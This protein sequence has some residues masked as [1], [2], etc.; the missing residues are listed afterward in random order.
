ML[1]AG[2]V[3]LIVAAIFIA[4][5]GLWYAA[6]D[7]VVP[8]TD[9]AQS[10]PVAL[11]S[12]DEV[13]LQAPEVTPPSPTKEVVARAESRAVSDPLA[14][15]NAAVR[16]EAVI[17]PADEHL[18]V[19]AASLAISGRILNPSGDPVAGIAVTASRTGHNQ[20]SS[21]ASDHRGRSDAAGVY[22]IQGLPAGEYRL[23]TSPT[24]VYPSA[25]IVA[26]A[27]LQSRISCWPRDIR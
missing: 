7:E 27:G 16:N 15:G 4:E 5:S 8:F 6:V 26:R 13:P 21:P 17:A 1:G 11:D 12:T 2:A 24:E 23:V 3:S 10:D 20:P 14:A 25:L 19:E 9:N 22:R 18:A